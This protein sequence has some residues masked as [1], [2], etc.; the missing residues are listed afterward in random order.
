VHRALA[1]DPENRFS[2]CE[3]MLDAIRS[4][5]PDGS[6]RTS[7]LHRLTDADKAKVAPKYVPEV[8]DTAP[9]PPARWWE[10]RRS[11][12]AL[13]AGAVVG[14]IGV[15]VMSY[16]SMHEE[17]RPRVDSTSTTA[18]LQPVATGVRTEEHAPAPPPAPR[19]PTMNAV[20]VAVVAPPAATI[21]V[22]GA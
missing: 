1:R 5:L 11:L 17:E 15:G 13:G 20:Q 21:E 2:S 19:E 8:V 22:D 9:E 3:E 18:S 16:G 6:I 14:L 7:M 4:V 12:G 10:P